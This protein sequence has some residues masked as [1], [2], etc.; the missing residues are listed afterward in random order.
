MVR[1]F[2]SIWGFYL[3]SAE[4]ARSEKVLALSGDVVP[5]PLEEVHHRLA[6]VDVVRIPLGGA[7]GHQRTG[8]QQQQV[9]LHRR[10]RRRRRRRRCV[11]VLQRNYGLYIL[12]DRG[13]SGVSG[14]MSVFP[15]R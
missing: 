14:A 15:L 5:F 11:A 4:T 6:A 13:A 3:N 10:R 7:G 2:F 9:R 12:V 8:R 1:V